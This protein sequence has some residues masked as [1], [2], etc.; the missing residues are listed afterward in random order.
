MCIYTVLIGD[1]PIGKNLLEEMANISQCGFSVTE[2]SVST[3]AAMEDFVRKVFL[4]KVSDSDGYGVLNT[5]D[6]CP[7][8]PRGV[9][10]DS[11]GCPLDSDG[12]GVYD[13]LDECPGTP[14]GVKVDSKGCPL[15]S[16]GD[17][18]YDDKDQC[19]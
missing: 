13:S 9:K 16:D 7:N 11:M 17:G 5:Y 4:T 3:P 12:D 19:L 8:T 15:D 1:S 6:R 14:K 18:V 2:D 10:V